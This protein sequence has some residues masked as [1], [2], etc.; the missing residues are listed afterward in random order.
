VHRAARDEVEAAALSMIELP[1]CTRSPYTSG[2]D[3]L[4]PPYTCG[5]VTRP[6]SMPE[7]PTENP[8]VLCSV[9]PAQN[10]WA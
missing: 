4:V 1:A 9:F 8:V 7:L 10:R 5:E 2:L 3:T 6:P